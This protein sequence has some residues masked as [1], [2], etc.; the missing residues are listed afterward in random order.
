MNQDSFNKYERV[1]ADDPNRCQGVTAQGQCPF[2]SVPGSKFCWIHG[3][4][5]H[6]ESENK[7]AVR[8]YQLAIWQS[9]L[10]EKQGPDIKSLR[11]EIGILRILIEERLNMCKT[12]TDLILVSGP[13]SDLIMK[14]Q[15]VIS[16]CH[17][18]EKSLG[19]LLDKTIIKQFAQEIIKIITE[20]IDDEEIIEHVALRIQECMS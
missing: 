5:K 10:D 12:A 1:E 6:L 20:E 2:K 4:N 18:L 17:T 16:S 13:I 19:D 8:N 14:L 15:K 11:E 9:R 7:K 3:G